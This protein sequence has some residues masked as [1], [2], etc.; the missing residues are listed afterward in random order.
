MLNAFCSCP[1]AR[2]LGGPLRCYPVNRAYG[3]STTT[4]PRAGSISIDELIAMA[5]SLKLDAVKAKAD[6]AAATK[7][8]ADLAAEAAD[9]AMAVADV[10]AAA[11]ASAGNWVSIL[12]QLIICAAK[13]TTLLCGWV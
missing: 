8:A 2:Q 1:T 6:A 11:A 9:A 7:V 10:A 12:L 3:T 13:K 4:N 5:S